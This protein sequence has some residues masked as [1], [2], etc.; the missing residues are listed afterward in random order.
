MSYL[1]IALSLLLSLPAH[2]V[3]QK[4]GANEHNTVWV[5]EGD[6]KFRCSLKQTIPNFGE[7]TFRHLAGGKLHLKVELIHPNRAEREVELISRP[8]LW[9]HNR[10][11]RLLDS[12]QLNEPTS[13][14]EF[15]THQ[16]RVALTELEQGLFPTI[17]YRVAKD[18]NREINA[19]ISSVNFQPAYNQF[20]TCLGQLMPYQFEYVQESNFY[21]RSG[22]SSLSA[23][24]RRRLN[25]IIT[26][27]KA[28]P[29]IKWAQIKGYT[30]SKGFRHFNDKLG[31]QRAKAIQNYLADH[32]VDQLD[33]NVKSYGERKP[34]E[35]NRTSKGRARNRVAIF[36]LFNKEPPP[37]EE[38][39][40]F[41]F[42]SI[43]DTLPKEEPQ[44]KAPI[45]T[46]LADSVLE[47]QSPP[48][49]PPTSE[50]APAEIS[51]PPPPTFDAPAESALVVPAPEKAAQP[52]EAPPT[53]TR[54]SLFE[55][56]TPDMV[57][58][59]R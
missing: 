25:E 7:A 30:D 3:T 28:D 1:L 9:L 34:L 6:N 4:F 8:P 42:E 38:L 45:P 32:G 15:G 24:D 27:V 31:E 48:M 36:T 49:M 52:A 51:P 20:L 21:F 56:I 13:E 53:D 44:Y 12:Q 14:I 39:P 10:G 41:E 22:R 18:D 17:R 55:P 54:P 11:S 19:A 59:G 46:P 37:P 58:T 29:T 35:S 43:F 23:I 33:I 5:S 26:Y 2:A 50:A 16:A 57:E 40:E 47:P